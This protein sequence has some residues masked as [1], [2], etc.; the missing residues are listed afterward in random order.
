MKL[1]T[2]RGGVLLPKEERFRQT[3]NLVVGIE[4]NLGVSEPKVGFWYRNQ[5]Q[6]NKE[7]AQAIYQRLREEVP[8]AY[9]MIN[10]L[11][12]TG[13]LKPITRKYLGL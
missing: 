3:R 6:A 12:P 10:K 8:E 9:S 1:G 11:L 7:T 4:P 5:F 2:Q 13:K